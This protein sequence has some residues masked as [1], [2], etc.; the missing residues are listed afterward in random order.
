MGPHGQ[1]Y[2][3][4][5]ND[6]VEMMNSGNFEPDPFKPKLKRSNWV[7]NKKKEE[8]D[9]ETVGAIVEPN[10]TTLTIDETDPVEEVPD[11]DNDESIYN[12]SEV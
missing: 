11:S 12:D 5:S 10:P 7:K 6:L 1:A 8:K 3:T 2:P 4:S 9:E